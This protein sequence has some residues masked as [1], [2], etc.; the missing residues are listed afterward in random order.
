M[1]ED[2]IIDSP[3]E[4]TEMDPAME[5]VV[6]EMEGGAVVEDSGECDACE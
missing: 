3:A 6:E 5:E 2:M 1:S 4:E